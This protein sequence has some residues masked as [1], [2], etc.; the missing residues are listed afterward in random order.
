MAFYDDKKPTV[1]PFEKFLAIPHQGQLKNSDY[2]TVDAAATLLY[3][4][5]PADVVTSILSPL[6]ENEF[7]T[8]SFPS[9]EIPGIGVMNGRYVTIK[10]V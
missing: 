7:T 5:I 8:L 3:D 9:S 6:S 2:T 1:D 10:M 4:Y